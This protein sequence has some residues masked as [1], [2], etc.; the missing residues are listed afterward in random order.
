MFSHVYIQRRRGHLFVC[1]MFRY[2]SCD[3]LNRSSY[4]IGV[5]ST[6][7]IHKATIDKVECF[8]QAHNV[9]QCVEL[10]DL[11]FSQLMCDTAQ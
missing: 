6:S 3:M 7:F 11:L 8:L 10:I 1:F 5:E 4:C 2:V 9:L